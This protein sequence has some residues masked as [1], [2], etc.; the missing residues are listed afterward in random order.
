MTCTFMDDYTCT[1]FLH[2]VFVFCCD[3]MVIFIRFR[4]S[5]LFAGRKIVSPNRR[6]DCSRFEIGGPLAYSLLKGVSPNRPTDCSRFEIGAPLANEA[7]I[8]TAATL[9]V[10]VRLRDVQTPADGPWRWLPGRGS[11][12]CSTGPWSGCPPP[13]RWGFEVVSI[14]QGPPAVHRQHRRPWQ[15]LW[16]QRPQSRRRC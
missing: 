13:F 15:R 8:W 7:L 11:V 1:F 10:I 6:T 4:Y 3:T 5:S 12:K 14:P 16:L 2:D 9:A